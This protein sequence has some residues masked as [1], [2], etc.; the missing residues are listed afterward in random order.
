M[1][2]TDKEKMLLF[3]ALESFQR[4]LSYDESRKTFTFNRSFY[5]PQ[6]K[7]FNNVFNEKE[8]TE[9][10]DKLLSSFCDD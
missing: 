5:S 3:Y 9:L 10:I 8:L 7:I 1:M 6:L 2:L 4:A